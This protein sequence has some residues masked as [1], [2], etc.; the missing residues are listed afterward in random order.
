MSEQSHEQQSAAEPADTETRYEYA[1]LV[2]S[3]ELGWE[4]HEAVSA[5]DLKKVYHR[6]FD[7]LQRE[8]E[9]GVTIRSAAEARSAGK[10]LRWIEAANVRPVR[11]P[12]AE[13]EDAEV[14]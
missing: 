6:Q 13:W 10:R 3:D 11:R 2:G 14:V 4:T 9:T 5:T 1:V 12:V 7:V 8:R